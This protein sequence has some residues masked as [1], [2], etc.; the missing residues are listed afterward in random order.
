MSLFK[1]V[2]QSY[3]LRSGFFKMIERV[4][5]IFFNLITFYVL[6]RYFST[7]EF[8]VWTLY[9]NVYTFLD[10]LRYGFISTGLMKAI[11]QS[12]QSD[13]YAEVETAALILNVG[14]TVLGSAVFWF[15]GEYIAHWMNAPQLAE[16]LKIYALVNFITVFFFHM[17]VM[18]QAN[19][20][21]KASSYGQFVFKAL[22]F[23]LAVGYVLISPEPTLNTLAILQGLAILGGTAVMF[24]YGRQHLSFR[25]LYRQP[26]LAELF[27]YGKW[28]FSTNASAII[29][30]SAD[31]WM[32]SG[33]IGPSAVAI[34]AVALKVANVLE[35]PVN[36]IASIMFPKMV[37]RLKEDGISS[38]RHMYERSVA[39]ILS[40]L[41]PVVIG[42]IVLADL[43]V[44][45][46]AGV[47]YEEAGPILQ[48]TVF[49]S[50]LMGLNKQVGVMLDATGR[51]HMNTIFVVRD[52]L[53]NLTL[54]YFFIKQF[55]VIGAALAT[56][57]TYTF[58]N[59]INQWYVHNVYG[60][61][62]IRYLTNMGNTYKQG[63]GMVKK[64]VKG[65]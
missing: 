49:Y 50:I 39:I 62:Q 47:G 53:I 36:V 55:G 32:L 17:D 10:L 16:L 52:A 26:A 40:I 51:A 13:E 6:V 9:L 37:Q 33:I 58:S 2:S 15:G 3:W 20:D 23:A 45:I 18:Q 7:E 41:I 65:A 22:Q 44:D 59:I 28:T 38:A 25:F 8:G 27:N 1:K 61:R 31:S 5:P 35:M 64:I 43:I 48:I 56:L 57:T 42:I 46:I 14:L 34:Y 4:S 11:G 29:M 24:I 60:V 30:R 54:N 63:F 19:M 12:T 21:F